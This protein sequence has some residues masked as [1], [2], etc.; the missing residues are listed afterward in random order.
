MSWDSEGALKALKAERCIVCEKVKPVHV[1][2]THHGVKDLHLPCCSD[3]C[4]MIVTEVIT[5][6]YEKMMIRRF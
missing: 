6:Q 4:M 2:V 5:E 3:D 1:V